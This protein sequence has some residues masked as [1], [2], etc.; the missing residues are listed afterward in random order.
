M[1][2]FFRSLALACSCFLIGQL[3]IGCGG[4]ATNT[5]AVQPPAGVNAASPAPPASSYPPLNSLVANAEFE[6]LD[7]TKF[8]PQDRKGNV[9]LLN[10]WATWCG[11]C[12]AEIPELVAINDK[13]K[14]SGVQVIG[15]DVG[16][17]SGKPE[18]TETIQKFAEK[19]KINY[20]LARIPLNSIR[21][22]AKVT[23]FDGVPQSLVVDR[24][25]RLRG[26]FLGGDPKTVN[27]MKETIETILAE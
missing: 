21:D 23:N 16:D 22:I 1:K 15:L 27:K 26:V 11:P 17:G 7:G 3:F 13:Y 6:M 14:E 9:L 12:R 4:T 10:L 24:Q 5:A 18:D 2:F 19:M 20:E 25:G 8:K